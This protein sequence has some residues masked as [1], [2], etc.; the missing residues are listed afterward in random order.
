MTLG[1]HVQM[2][3]YVTT[4]ALSASSLSSPLCSAL[5]YSTLLCPVEISPPARLVRL[6]MESRLLKDVEVGVGI[7]GEL[8]WVCWD[9]GEMDEIV[10]GT[11]MNTVKVG[12]CL[13]CH[14]KKI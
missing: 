1:E 12:M 7:G 5:L 11:K 2:Y 4:Y 8:S 14:A 13:S 9:G 3:M 6:E 10:S